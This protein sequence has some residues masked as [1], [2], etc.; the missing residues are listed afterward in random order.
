MNLLQYIDRFSF[1]QVL[2]AAII[3]AIVFAIPTTVWLVNQQTRLYSAAH[4]SKLPPSFL[5]EAEPFGAPSANP[6]KIDSITPFLGKVDDIVIIKGKDFGQNPQQRAIWFGTT[7][8]DEQDIIRWHDD[9][10][11]VMV[12]D[13]ASSGLVKVVEVDKE[14][15]YS[16]PFTIYDANTQVRVFWQ[17]S[18]LA[19]ENGFSVQR[20]K[21]VLRSGQTTEA[22]VRDQKTVTTLLENVPSHD[23]ANLSL[24]D[25]N[26][27]LVSFYVNP[28]EFGF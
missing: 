26:G 2:S 8:A 15:T 19:V 16:L 3:V 27:Q 4:K 25:K 1:K 28:T 24:Y 23:F 7:K 14:D 20:V 17:G 11:Q 18:N 12:P 13:G 9:E 10:I 5:A 21:L 22:E 6:P